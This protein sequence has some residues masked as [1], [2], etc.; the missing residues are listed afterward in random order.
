MWEHGFNHIDCHIHTLAMRPY[1]TLSTLDPELILPVASSTHATNIVLRI[2]LFYHLLFTTPIIWLLQNDKIQLIWKVNWFFNDTQ[3][4]KPF[5][6]NKQI[7]IV[8]IQVFMKIFY[9]LITYNL[10]KRL[11]LN[12]FLVNPPDLFLPNTHTDK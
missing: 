5:D 2:T 8:I 11:R 10:S 12:M 4:N 7:I 1:L 3:P 6:S 9:T